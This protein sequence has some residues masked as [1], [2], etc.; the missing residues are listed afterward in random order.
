MGWAAR[1]GIKTN[2]QSVP[3]IVEKRYRVKHIPEAWAQGRGFT[4]TRG[5]EYVVAPDGSLR[6]LYPEPVENTLPKPSS[7]PYSS[8]SE[9]VDCRYCGVSMR[10]THTEPDGT[11]RYRCS[12][13]S[14]EEAVS[15]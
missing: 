12:E 4:D 11:K 6:R 2:N 1:N 13:C 7:E 14:S 10:L 3:S 8:A 15:G 9:K 5:R